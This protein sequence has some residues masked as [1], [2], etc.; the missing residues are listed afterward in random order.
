VTAC[1]RNEQLF[2]AML[3]ASITDAFE[4]DMNALP[5][6][7][8]LYAHQPSPALDRRIDRLIKKS[9]LRI[10]AKRFTSRLGKAA[11]FFC[12]LLTVA[13]VILMSVSA[14]RNAIFNAILKWHEQYTEIRFGESSER[15]FYRPAYLP[16]GFSEQTFE[17]GDNYTTIVYKNSNGE[18]LVLD[19]QAADTGVNLV[20]NENTDYS[21]IQIHGNTGYLFKA[22]TESDANIVIWE[23]NGIVLELIST[24][25]SDELL[26]VAESMKNN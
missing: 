22:K 11:A 4:R 1:E 26:R 6:Y 19:Q 17:A 5:D 24:L 20:D 18:K 21:E 3:R 23:Q 9:Y 7:D 25:E 16:A 2:D 15:H 13:S 12:I 8:A 14:T 10:K